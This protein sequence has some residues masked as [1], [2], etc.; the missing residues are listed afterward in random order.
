MGRLIS[1]HM[2]LVFG[3]SLTVWSMPWAKPRPKKSLVNLLSLRL[4]RF[5]PNQTC[6][7]RTGRIL[8]AED[9]PINQRVALGQLRNLRYKANAVANGLGVL[10]ALEQISYEIILMDCQ[11]PEIDGYEATRAI[12]K[13]EQSLEEPC[14]WKSPVYIIAM[15]A[16]AM[17]G[18][19]EKEDTSPPSV[20][21]EL[22]LASRSVHKKLS[23]DFL[24]L[25][26]PK[27]FVQP[28][29][30]PVKFLGGRPSSTVVPLLL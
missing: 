12:R 9:N 29:R 8:L 22:A 1:D 5:P 14:P 26:N 23:L 7:S 18:D 24:H 15:I 3:V 25:G 27:T 16:N 13:R 4:S 17:Q 6:N 21:G 11:M 2:L 28:L 20:L 19:R 30:S 10:Q